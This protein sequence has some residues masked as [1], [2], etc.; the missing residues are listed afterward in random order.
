MSSI[1]QTISITIAKRPWYEWLLWALWVVAEVFIAQNA[2]ASSQ[3]LEPQA[4][5]IF[6]VTFAVLLVGG[7]IVWFVRRNRAEK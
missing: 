5:L 1:P 2:I 6:W 7:A 3:E 4:A